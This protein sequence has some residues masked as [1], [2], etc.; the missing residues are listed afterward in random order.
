MNEQKAQ[1]D[2]QT[3]INM[4]F[5]EAIQRMSKDDRV[6]LWMH[7]LEKVDEILNTANTGWQLE[8][9]NNVRRKLVYQLNL[10][11][12]DKVYEK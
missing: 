3:E 4:T 5:K 8:F 9:W 12:I 7:R 2:I 6:S 11:S 1:T 10:L